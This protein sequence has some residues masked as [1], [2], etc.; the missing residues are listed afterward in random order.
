MNEKPLIEIVGLKKSFQQPDGGELKVLDGIDLTVQKNSLTT[1]IGPSGCGKS[2]F[3]NVLTGLEAPTEGEIRFHSQEKK[4]FKFGY[5]FQAARLLPWMKVIDNVLFVHR[6]QTAES[7]KLAQHYLEVVGLKD[8]VDVYPHQLSGGMQQRVGIA[9][10]L[11]LEPDILL[12]D[13]PFSHLDEITAKKMRRDL[14]G[15]WKESKVTIL[16]VTHDLSEAAILSDRVLFLCQKPAKVEEDVVIDIPRPRKLHDEDF[17]SLHARLSQKFS[18]ME[19]DEEL[20]D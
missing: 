4:T 20:L 2:T 10:A 3:L 14:I 5:V 13:E 19:G 11:S 7:R 16:F 18:F 12:M 17:L 15:I 6:V 8:F 9:R 1:L